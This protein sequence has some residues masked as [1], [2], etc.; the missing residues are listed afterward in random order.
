MLV[1]TC[2]NFKLHKPVAIF[3]M[4]LNVFYGPMFLSIKPKLDSVTLNKN[5][6]APTDCL[7]LLGLESKAFILLLV[8]NTITHLNVLKMEPNSECHSRVR[9]GCERS[10]YSGAFKKSRLYM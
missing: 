5:T 3:S 9:G 10:V 1:T 2:L 7:Q 8:G 4:S 6:D